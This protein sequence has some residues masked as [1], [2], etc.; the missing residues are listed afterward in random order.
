MAP[1]PHRR[2]YV[3]LKATPALLALYRARDLPGL[4]RAA[5]ALLDGAA[6]ATATPPGYPG[7]STGTSTGTSH[8]TA[9]VPAPDGGAAFVSGIRVAG[10]PS[11]SWRSA[12]VPRRAGT[13]PGATILAHD[14]V[15]ETLIVPF[16]VETDTRL[17]SVLR[18]IDAN[19]RTPGGIILAAGADP[20]GSVADHWC[21]GPAGL[22]AFGHRRLAKQT[23]RAAALEAHGLR[24]QSVNVAIVD[25]G[26]NKNGIPAANWGG[27]L[28]HYIDNDLV[29]PAGSAPRR[30]HGMMIAR[31]ILDLAPDARLYDVPVIPSVAGQTGLRL[32]VSTVHSAYES[33]MHEIAARRAIPEW[34]GPWIFVN[35][36]GIFDTESDPTGSYVRNL[37]P[38]GHPMVNLITQAVE[39]GGFD[40]VFAAGNCGQFCPSQQCGA[41]DRG[42]GHGI[43]GVNAHS[44]VIAVGAV[45]SDATWLGFSSQGSDR[46]APA[47][48]APL[49]SR[50]PDICAPSQ[51]VEQTDAGLL[52]SGTS[53]A[54]GMAAGV[55]AA[56]R[57]NPKWNQT[58]LP[59]AHLK[60]A[61]SVS[62]RK[63][64]GAPRWDNRLGFGIIDAAAAIGLLPP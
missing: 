11:T 15:P 53:A 32:F 27:G 9:A 22:A 19:L 48:A 41:L 42:P 33:L 52:S 45:R 54:C 51:F 17:Q 55:V 58:D 23:M 31:S 7:T 36:W 18:N 6:P 62:A 37:A 35:A 5:A 56:L 24:G 4:T 29:L 39:T 59:P 12:F 10:T 20:G 21:P 50:K 44:S 43:W 25:E 57:G 2:V 16:E 26:L 38:G 30:S 60:A 47:D 61:L 46:A 13:V 28:D 1:C 49:T 63:Q 14:I 3:T 40:V 34:S 8:G 64:P